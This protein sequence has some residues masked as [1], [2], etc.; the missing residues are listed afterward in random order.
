MKNLIIPIILL[1]L[2]SCK[3]KIKDS[4]NTNKET[5]ITEITYVNGDKEVVVL[6]SKPIISSESCLWVRNSDGDY[7]HQYCFVRKIKFLQPT[8]TLQLESKMKYMDSL[9]QIIDKY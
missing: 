3:D 4:P 9:K 2:Y 7:I 6:N 5:Y 1:S 8:D